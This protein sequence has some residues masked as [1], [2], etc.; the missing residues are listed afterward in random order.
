MRLIFLSIF[1]YFT[2]FVCAQEDDRGYIVQLGDQV[3]DFEMQ[4]ISGEKVRI[5]D[6]KGK[7]VMLQFTASWCG[8]CRREMPFIEEEIWSKLKD[9]A[10]FRLY[11][12]DRDEPLEKVTWFANRVGISYALAL[13]PDAK[14]FQLFALKESGVTRNV[15]IDRDGS[16]VYLT[17]LFNRE[18]FDAMKKLIFELIE[19]K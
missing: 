15:I 4:L 1:I 17:R 7:V 2:L 3:P 19:I 18:E 6:L 5:S 13:D 14:I 12:I 16:I 10:D 8:V 11:G 9:N